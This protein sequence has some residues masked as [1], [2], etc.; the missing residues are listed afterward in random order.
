MT[1][2]S[3]NLMNNQ[4]PQPEKRGRGRPRKYPKVE[5]DV[6]N[7]KGHPRVRPFGPK[8]QVGRPRLPDDQKKPPLRKPTGRPRG[9][10]R[11]NSKPIQPVESKRILVDRQ[12]YKELLETEQNF[13]VVKNTIGSFFGNP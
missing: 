1:S 4:E 8:R 2:D 5:N 10:P 13:V 7:P 3:Q 9:R 11:L 12:K 6:K